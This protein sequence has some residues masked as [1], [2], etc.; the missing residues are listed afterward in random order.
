MNLQL[1]LEK[2]KW[3]LD[4]PPAKKSKVLITGFHR[5][6]QA[7][8]RMCASCNSQIRKLE[9]KRLLTLGKRAKTRLGG[10]PRADLPSPWCCVLRT[11]RSKGRCCWPRKMLMFLGVSQSSPK[12]THQMEMDN[13]NHSWRQTWEPILWPQPEPLCTAMP[14]NCYSP[15]STFLPLGIPEYGSQVATFTHWFLTKSV[16][17]YFFNIGTFVILEHCLCCWV[18]EETILFWIL[19]QVVGCVCVCVYSLLQ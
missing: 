19:N 18:Q 10:L 6:A 16:P 11:G 2:W 1:T 17:K 14:S 3:L 15:W 13:V 9:R 12:L 8:T 7:L 5:A 4:W